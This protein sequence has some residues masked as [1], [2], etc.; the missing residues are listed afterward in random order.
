MLDTPAGRAVFRSYRVIWTPTIAILDRRGVL[1]YQ[2]PGYLP[3]LDFLA[4]A[5]IGVARAMT[6]WGRYD[7]AV[8]LLETAANSATT[9]APEALYW[10][11]VARYLQRHTRPAL[12]ESWGRLLA[13]HPGSVWASRV[14]PGQDAPEEDG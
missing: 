12:M 6:A 9:L 14:P 5:Q 13:E 10:Q 7:A 4:M 8:A 11:G 3:P 2:S 1:H